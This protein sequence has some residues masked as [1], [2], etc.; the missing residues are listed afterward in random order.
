M[1]VAYYE[2]GQLQEALDAAQIVLLRDE[3]LAPAH[4]VLGAVALESQQP[5]EALPYL[6]RAI[7]LD[8]GYSQAHFYLGLAYRALKRPVDAIGAFEQ[9]LIAAND[10]VTRVRIRRHLN[11]LYEEERQIRSP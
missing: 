4:A 5:E 7:E 9:A 8:A 10:E 6:Q 3:A 1:A 11:E 2:A